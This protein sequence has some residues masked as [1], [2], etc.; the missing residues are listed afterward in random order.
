MRSALP[1]ILPAICLKT[2]LHEAIKV[3]DAECGIARL[4]TLCARTK[5]NI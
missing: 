4:L 5:K 2:R 1:K 3:H